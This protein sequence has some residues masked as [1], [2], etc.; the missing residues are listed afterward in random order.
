MNCPHC[1]GDG[2]ARNVT[3]WITGRFKDGHLLSD[4]GIELTD[5]TVDE[6]AKAFETWVQ[7]NNVTVTPEQM[8]KLDQLFGRF[9]WG[10]E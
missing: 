8:E 5:Y 6:E 2:K 7:W 9:I 4:I 10:L 3:G 1:R